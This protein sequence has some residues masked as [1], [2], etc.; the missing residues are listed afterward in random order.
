MF[1]NFSWQYCT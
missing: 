1:S